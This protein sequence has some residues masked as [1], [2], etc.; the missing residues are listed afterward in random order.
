MTVDEKYEKWLNHLHWFLVFGGLIKEETIL[1]RKSWR[2][3]FDDGLNPAE[4]VKE[5]MGQFP[6]SMLYSKKLK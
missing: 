5:D 4:A 1:C 6:L 3:Y 2:M